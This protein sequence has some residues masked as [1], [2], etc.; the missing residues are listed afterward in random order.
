MKC[1][2]VKKLFPDYLMMETD[3][4][5]AVK[6]EE[7]ISECEKCREELETSGAIWTKLEVLPLEFPGENLKKSFYKMLDSEIEKEKEI[8]EKK[9]FMSEIL[10]FIF[11]Q[12]RLLSPAALMLLVLSGFLLGVFISS[13]RGVGISGDSVIPEGNKIVHIMTSDQAGIINILNAYEDL[14]SGTEKNPRTLHK[15]KDPADM[16]IFEFF[17]EAAFNFTEYFGKVI[18]L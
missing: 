17:A 3:S 10:G 11:F 2:D 16:N 18:T 12:K 6:I 13:G 15:K 4:E 8:I 1:E 9:G 14:R 7:H 5:L